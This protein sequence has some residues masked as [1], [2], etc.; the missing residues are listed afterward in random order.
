M[1]TR[2][3]LWFAIVFS[4]LVYGILA[5]ASQRNFTL[6]P[7]SAA[8]RRPIVLAIYLIALAV[9]AAAFL[10]PAAI[11]RHGAAGGTPRSAASASLAATAVR[12]ALLE[13]VAILGLAAAFVI[14][15]WRLYLPAWALSLAGFARSSPWSG[16]AR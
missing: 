1:S 3:F 9:Y 2:R 8:L 16:D 11:A 5:Y 7:V 15:D 6:Q 14:H 10:A 12:F 4:T 13:A